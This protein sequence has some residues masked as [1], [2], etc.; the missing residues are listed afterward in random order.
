MY[1]VKIIR[2]WCKGCRVCEKLCP[3]GVFYIVYSENEL[4]GK[5][6]FYPVC[7]VKD[8]KN[9]VGCRICEKHCSM[10][11]IRITPLLK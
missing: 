1:E 11:A 9:C 6:H 2:E 8:M 7:E 10:F 5:K 4:T 3:R